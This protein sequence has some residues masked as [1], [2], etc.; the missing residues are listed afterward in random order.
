MICDGGNW[1]RWKLAILVNF[2]RHVINISIKVLGIWWK[3]D[4]FSNVLKKFINYVKTLNTNISPFILSYNQSDFLAV[5][6]IKHKCCH[7]KHRKEYFFFF[8]C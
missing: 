1:S 5:K 7:H 4:I 8:Q 2:T 6:N 3:N